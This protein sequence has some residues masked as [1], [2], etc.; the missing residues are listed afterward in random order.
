M[1]SQ[2]E[3]SK[4]QYSHNDSVVSPSGPPDSVLVDTLTDA[5]N[6]SVPSLAL[7]EI[8]SHDSIGM[9]IGR[10]SPA[11]AGIC[12][13]D[14]DNTDVEEKSNVSVCKG[15]NT[16]CELQTG[17]N[18]DTCNTVYDHFQEIQTGNSSLQMT[19]SSRSLDV[20]MTVCNNNQHEDLK[21]NS[22]LCEYL[23]NSDVSLFWR[24]PPFTMTCI[25]SFSHAF[26]ITALLVNAILGISAQLNIPDIRGAILISI[27]GISSLVARLTHGWI[28]D[29]QCISYGKFFGISILICG[30]AT[31]LMPITTNFEQMA[32]FCVVVGLTSGTYNPLTAVVIREHVGLNKLNSGIGLGLIP[33]IGLGNLLGA[34][35]TGERIEMY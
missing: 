9:S 2:N 14:N 23:R 27:V 4:N 28:A 30:V 24:N 18:C 6:V 35:C 17:K 21:G 25:A 11:T 20:T 29:L 15:D 16:V 31:L 5:S 10:D 7:G 26:G 34:F 22:R 32:G 12:C 19:E 8:V 3:E 13:L 33:F 1:E